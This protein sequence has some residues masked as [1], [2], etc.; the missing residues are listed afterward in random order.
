M[1]TFKQIQ[2]KSN[3]GSTRAASTSPRLQPSRSSV[4]AQVTTSGQVFPDQ[5]TQLQYSPHLRY[6]LADIPVFPPKRENSTGLPDN[7]KAGIE[8]LSG[9]SMDDVEVHYNSPKPAQ[10]Q[11]A[12]YTQGTEIHVGPGQEQHLPHEVWH[13]VQQKQGRV[14]PTLQAKGVAINDDST[15]ESE[16]D[17]IGGKAKQVSPEGG[18]ESIGESV[19]FQGRTDSDIGQ[20][21]T[22]QEA[23]VPSA[24]RLVMQLMKLSNLKQSGFIYQHHSS[25]VTYKLLNLPNNYH[26]SIFP[27]DTTYRNFPDLGKAPQKPHDL[28]R[29]PSDD[30][31]EFDELHITYEGGRREHFFYNTQGEPLAGPISK[32]A[33]GGHSVDWNDGR[34]YETNQIIANLRGESV[35]DINRKWEATVYPQTPAP[36]VKQSG[37]KGNQPK[38]SV[39]AIPPDVQERMRQEALRTSKPQGQKRESTTRSFSGQ[40]TTKNPSFTFKLSNTFNFEPTQ[41][42]PIETTPIKPQ[43]FQSIGTLPIETTPTQSQ[44]KVP[45]IELEEQAKK[46]KVPEEEE[47]SKDQ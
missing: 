15:L 21:Q 44:S 28:R 9:I 35:D 3:I 34:W 41:Q 43:T 45:L 1:G 24:Y 38:K 32:Y 47:E 42:S 11:A 7:L 46:R 16:A 19:E 8:N 10:V 14:K 20:I 22:Q 29:L 27:N 26:V 17:T 5:Q 33:R 6:S 36:E 2:R 39:I 40:T 12:A 18:L 31:F 37:T 25:N 4:P 30:E 23:Q 13:V